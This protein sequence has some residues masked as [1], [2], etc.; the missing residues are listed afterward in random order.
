MSLQELPHMCQL[1]E[2]VSCHTFVS[3][4]PPG[5]V[6]LVYMFLHE[7]MDQGLIC[8]RVH[9]CDMGLDHK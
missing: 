9:Q 1:C 7:C 5:G 6:G 4:H 2:W 8:L 3:Q